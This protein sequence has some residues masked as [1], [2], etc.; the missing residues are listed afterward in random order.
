MVEISFYMNYCSLPQMTQLQLSWAESTEKVSSDGWN[1]P[2]HLFF[3][4]LST[5]GSFLFYPN[6][7]NAL[8]FVQLSFIT[9]FLFFN[10]CFWFPFYFPSSWSKYSGYCIDLQVCHDGNICLFYWMLR[11]TQRHP[12]LPAIAPFSWTKE[13]RESAQ[14]NRINKNEPQGKLRKG[15]GLPSLAA[16]HVQYSSNSA[17]EQTS[18][19]PSSLVSHHHVMQRQKK[20]IS[21]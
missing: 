9:I 17:T 18:P 14:L 19:C 3:S 15:L 21:K 13:M 7:F 10:S 2:F 6:C 1:K 12:R 5:L 11:S 8:R 20:K 16:Q 4:A